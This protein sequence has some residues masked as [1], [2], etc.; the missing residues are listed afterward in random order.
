[1]F[2]REI[3]LFSDLTIVVAL[4]TPALPQ[5]PFPLFDLLNVPSRSSI[6]ETVGAHCSRLVG[7]LPDADA[8]PR[9]QATPM[10]ANP[11][12]ATKIFAGPIRDYYHL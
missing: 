5:R 1:M 11:P 10:K 8:E 9:L 7:D 3:Q 12:W 4:P 6:L 2:H